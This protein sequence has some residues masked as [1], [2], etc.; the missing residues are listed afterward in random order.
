VIGVLDLHPGQG[1]AGGGQI[2]ALVGEG[3]FVQPELPTRSL[4]LAARNDLVTFF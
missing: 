4:P 3:F 1:A 2:I